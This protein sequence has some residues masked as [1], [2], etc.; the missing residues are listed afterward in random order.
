MKR[1]QEIP[2][3]ERAEEVNTAPRRDRRLKEDDVDL[4][5]RDNLDYD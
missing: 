1:Q 5:H 2:N 3:L 4:D